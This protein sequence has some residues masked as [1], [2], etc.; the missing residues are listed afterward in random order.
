MPERITTFDVDVWR[1]MRFFMHKYSVCFIIVAEIP[2]GFRLFVRINRILFISPSGFC[3]FHLAIGQPK[4][5]Q[6]KMYFLFDCSTIHSTWNCWCFSFSLY[7]RLQ[8]KIRNTKHS[9]KVFFF[10]FIFISRFVFESC[11]S[12]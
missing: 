7:Y 4:L 10:A 11:F 8:F 3:S 2:F 12:F 6:K 5:A 9:K 1:I